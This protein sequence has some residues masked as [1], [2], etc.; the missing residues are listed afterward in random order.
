MK[1]IT[2]MKPSKKDYKTISRIKLN[3]IAKKLLTK[4]MRIHGIKP[5]NSATIVEE[6]YY[7][8]RRYIVIGSF[9]CSSDDSLYK[10]SYRYGYLY[11]RF[12]EL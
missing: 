9:Y 3:I 4:A 8:K 2:A 10:T 12:R 7:E 1:T 11:F 5:N 6:L